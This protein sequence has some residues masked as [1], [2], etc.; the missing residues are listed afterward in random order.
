MRVDLGFLLNARQALLPLPLV[1]RVPAPP[2][3]VLPPFRPRAEQPRRQVVAA[4][5]SAASVGMI[6]AARVFEEADARPAGI[7]ACAASAW[8]GAMWAAGVSADEMVASALGW[9]P[10][11][12]LGVQWTGLPRFTASALRGFGGLSKDAALEA[13]FDRRT[14][15]MSAGSTE[16]PFRTLAYD[17]D[18]RSFEVLG[19]ETTPEVTLGELARVAAALP[20]KSQAVR[21]EGRFYVDAMAAPGFAEDRLGEGEL[22]A[23]GDWDF[24]GLFLDRRR[25][26]E[27]IRAGYDSYA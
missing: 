3:D 20:S 24:Y 25:W 9:R 22:L 23:S 27:L 26:P 8:W 4:D 13:L 19:S 17:M 15:R 21:I 5:G 14:W 10:E 1:D 7:T 16:I 11:P 12:H 18:R 6:G 2:A